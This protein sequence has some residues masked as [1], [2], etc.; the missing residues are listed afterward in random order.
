MSYMNITRHRR[1][2][3]RRGLGLGDD[4]F[5]SLLAA[6][7]DQFVDATKQIAG[8]ADDPAI[9]DIESPTPL[10]A[11]VPVWNMSI[12]GICKPGDKNTLFT[13]TGFQKQLN[14]VADI[15]GIAKIGVDGDLGPKTLG[16]FRQVQSLAGGQISGDGS[17]CAG[18]TESLPV[19]AVQV[20]QFADSLGAPARTSSPPAPTPTFISQATGQEVKVPQAGASVADMFM[21]MS[22]PMKVAFAGVLGGIGYFAYRAMA[23]AP[24]SSSRARTKRRRR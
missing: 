15:K 10:Q 4:G 14:R 17:T 8:Q 6:G 23:P 7:F 3:R 2:L 24:S 13:V 16:L 21:G 19:I 22:T 5:A 20:A 9:T 1:F 12:P 18:L 11:S